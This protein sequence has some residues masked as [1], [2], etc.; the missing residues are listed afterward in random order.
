MKEKFLSLLNG[1]SII[2][3]FNTFVRYVFGTF[4]FVY[5]FKGGIQRVCVCK[6]IKKTLLDVNVRLNP[7]VDREREIFNILTSY[8]IHLMSAVMVS[9]KERVYS[10][11]QTSIIRLW[12]FQ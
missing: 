8:S 3:I 7:F 10:G 6:F 4:E 11:V 12:D 9:I 2:K 1:L 5:K